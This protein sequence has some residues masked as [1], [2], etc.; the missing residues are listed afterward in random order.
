VN[1]QSI[2][3]AHVTTIDASLRLLLLNQLTALRAKGYDVSGL[4][5]DGPDVP[6]LRAAGVHHI[7]I[8]TSRR[9]TPLE[10]LRALFFLLRVMRREKFSV[11][12]THT[13]KAG[14]LG[15]YAALL[16]GIPVRVHTIHGL[17]FPGHMNPRAR[18]LYVLLERITMAFSHYN[19][20]QNPEDIAVI[21]EE[22]ISRPDRLEL[23]GNGI[24]IRAFDPALQPPEKRST[25]R[26]SLGLTNE[27]L[28]VGVVA[29]LVDEK[30]YREMFRAVETIRMKEPRARFIFVGGF[31]P[32]KS[33]AIPLDTLHGLGISDVAQFLGHRNDVPDLYAIM[34]VHVLPSH[35]EGF[36]R[37][38]MEA[39]AMGVPS[40][41]T[42]VRG[43]RQTVDDGVTGR[44]VPARDPHALA[45]AIEELLGDPLKRRAFGSA[46][47]AK[48]LMEFDEQVVFARITAAYERLLS[49][50]AER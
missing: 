12:H 5:A 50:L 44:I 27:H 49:E 35:R 33:D 41:V 30:G 43:C 34:D 11:V 19:F 13:P 8:P 42:N 20:S 28:V 45:T 25:M 18:F 38:P 7:P 4:S 36:P 29:R 15:Q 3:V 1:R 32:S 31:D 40:V 47:R 9:F 6:T 46:A 14:L 39:S 37:S 21:L 17:Y 24:D 26:V 16:A 2:R 10:D 23:I 22:K 48:A